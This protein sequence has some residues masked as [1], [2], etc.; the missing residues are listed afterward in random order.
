MKFLTEIFDFMFAPAGTFDSDSGAMGTS[1]D[2]NFVEHE[3]TIV[4]PA[5]GMP[6]I[7]G[8]GGM[9]GIDVLGNPYGVDLHS[10]HADDH[11]AMF[12][13]ADCDSAV[14]HSMTMFDDSAMH[15][16]ASTFDDSSMFD[17]SSSSTGSAFD[18]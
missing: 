10:Y 11:S 6:M 1:G 14:D 8:S 5:N 7:E 2:N 18:D 13:H 4:N 12:N 17:C 3:S 9:G 16:S 15:T